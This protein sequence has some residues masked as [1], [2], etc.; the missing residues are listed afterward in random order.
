[1]K[2]STTTT[3]TIYEHCPLPPI[4]KF[5]NLKKER[6][7]KTQAKQ[8]DLFCVGDLKESLD[9]I[10][11][12]FWKSILTPEFLCLVSKPSKLYFEIKHKKEESTLGKSLTTVWG[13]TQ[14]RTKCRPLPLICCFI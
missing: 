2:Q 13:R 4:I 9:S 1:M 3:V 6:K 11:V 7:A 12:F 5:L 8:G 14:D 10:L